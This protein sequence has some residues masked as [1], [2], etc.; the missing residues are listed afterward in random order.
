MVKNP[1]ASAGDT[2]L[3][4]NPGWGRSSR[5]G[6]GNPLQYSCLGNPMDRGA[7][8]AIVWGSQKVS[9]DSNWTHTR[10]FSSVQFSCSVVSHSLQPHELQHARPPCPSPTPGVHSNSCPSS[11]WCD[12]AISSSF[13]PFSSCPQSLPASESFPMSQLFI[14]GGQSIAVSG[15]ASVLPMNTLDWWCLNWTELIELSRIKTFLLLP[16]GSYPCLCNLMVYT[17]YNFLCTGS[18]GEWMQ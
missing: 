17:P 11:R 1:P 12:P 2:D 15:S 14:W 7:W 3:G 4:S 18:G 16:F 9:Y 10:Q 5:T 13:V 6:S 8:R